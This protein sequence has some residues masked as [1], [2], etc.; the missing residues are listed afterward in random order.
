MR[1]KNF[2]PLVFSFLLFSL[3]AEEL[4]SINF[5]D[6]DI[7]V[8][9][10]F[11][12][13]VT[14]K[15][16]LLSDQVRGKV[17]VISPTKIPRDEV[18]KVFESILEIKGLTA[19]PSGKVIKIV[20]AREARQYPLPVNI[21]KKAEE[22]G[23]EDKMVTQLVPLEYADVQ[24]VSS[25]LNPLVS[26]EGHITSYPPTN[27]L[28]LSDYASNIRRLLRIVDRIDQPQAKMVTEII[29]LQYASATQ[30]S[31]AISQV[32]ETI[33]GKTGSVS[34]TRIRTVRRTTP[35]LSYTPPPPRIIPD[36]RTNS[37][38]VVASLQDMKRI[39]KL[40]EKLDVPAPRGK[41]N[42]LGRLR[43]GSQ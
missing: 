25:I 18:Y 32:L 34:R 15:N 39:K 17:T 30:L 19:I 43:A 12:S 8:V 7:S 28:I 2:I 4:V 40:V 14:G 36:E 38:V 5:S 3:S 9:A 35:T 16:F 21:G 6:V 31:Q 22:I 11:V 13:Q 10:R 27:T 20:P 41:E 1:I 29:P 24:Q 42:L 23:E 26:P 37:L 33:Q